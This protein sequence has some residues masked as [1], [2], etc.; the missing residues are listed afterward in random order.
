MEIEI[1]TIIDNYVNLLKKIREK[2]GNG[3]DSLAILAEIRKDLRAQQ[4][5]QKRVINGDMPATENQ[6]RYMKYLGLEIPEN[7]TRQQ[8][9]KLIDE[10]KEKKDMQKSLEQPIRIP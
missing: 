2:V 8:A 9:S 7:L 1:N 3:P 4:P 10:G 6:I 5:Q